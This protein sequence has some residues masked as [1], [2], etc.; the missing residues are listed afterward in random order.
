MADSAFTPSTHPLAI[1]DFLD[2]PVLP[3]DLSL[4]FTHSSYTLSSVKWFK[5][6]VP[7]RANGQTLGIGDKSWD[8][9]PLPLSGEKRRRAEE[10]FWLCLRDVTS[11]IA[12][13]VAALPDYF[14]LGE[15]STYSSR[16]FSLTCTL[17]PTSF[18]RTTVLSYLTEYAAESCSVFLG[19]VDDTTRHSFSA[20]YFTLLSQSKI[21]VTV[22]PPSWEGDH[23]LFESLASGALVFVDEESRHLLSLL[24]LRDREHVVLYSIKDGDHL[25]E[26][27]RHYQEN[28]EAAESIA[29]RG[30][31]K[32]REEMMPENRIDTIME[33]T[34]GV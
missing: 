4:L 10:V 2:S 32:A 7:M 11:N 24:G 9:L 5:R 25:K 20:P 31:E 21:V 8:L 33:A 26:L 6:S 13:L 28:E 16:K 18:T 14:S 23:R 29:G 12:S 27:L 3:Y 1:V 34:V 17:R 19:Q 15:A 30:R 22:N